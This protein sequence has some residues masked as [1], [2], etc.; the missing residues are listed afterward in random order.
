MSEWEPDDLVELRIRGEFVDVVGLLST[1]T[2]GVIDADE[3]NR[4]TNVAHDLADQAKTQVNFGL[5]ERQLKRIARNGD[6]EYRGIDIRVHE[7]DPRHPDERSELDVDK[8]PPF[9]EADTY[10]VVLENEE[11]L[12]MAGYPDELETDT[13]LKLSSALRL[14]ARDIEDAVVMEES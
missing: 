11:G 3:N 7:F 10:A 13:A 2:V 8:L 4:A 5:A 12:H 6:H 14:Y 9:E 1:M